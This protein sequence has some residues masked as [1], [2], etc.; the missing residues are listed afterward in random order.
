M[1][2]Q[3]ISWAFDTF[4]SIVIKL[5][6]GQRS[7]MDGHQ[8]CRK[9]LCFVCAGT[10]QG[11]HITKNIEGFVKLFVKGASNYSIEDVKTPNGKQFKTGWVIHFAF[12]LTEV[13]KVQW[14]RKCQPF[15]AFPNCPSRH[16]ETFCKILRFV[17]Y[18]ILRD[19]N[20]I[21]HILWGACLE[22][23]SV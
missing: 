5:C 9:N 21:W 22:E 10:S 11:N 18:F 13:L 17:G 4:F 6:E 15:L 12:Y 16:Y 7:K 23:K 3:N 19:T 20:V 1:H 14:H 8:K 2:Q